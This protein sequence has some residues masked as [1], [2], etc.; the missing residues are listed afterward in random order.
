MSSH[1]RHDGRSGNH[2]QDVPR[3]H[4]D[5]TTCGRSDK[6]EPCNARASGI[7][8]RTPGHSDPNGFILSPGKCHEE[9]AGELFQEEDA[10]SLLLRGPGHGRP[11]Q[12]TS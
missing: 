4:L 11:D 10:D 12:G 5:P 7:L 2:T 6:D 8:G 1:L 9:V 3:R